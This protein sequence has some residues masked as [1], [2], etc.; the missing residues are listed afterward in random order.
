MLQAMNT[1]HEG[2]LSTAHA[3]SCRH[4]LWRLET[5]AM[6]SDVE[7]PA[8]H[9]RNAGCV[10]DRCRRA[11]RAPARR[12]TSRVGDRRRRGDASRRAGRDAAVPV[13]PRERDDDRCV[14][15]DRGRAGRRGRPRAIEARTSATGSSR[16]ARTDDRA[17]RRPVW[18][19]RAVRGAGVR[20]SL[21]QSG[22]AGR[23]GSNDGIGARLDQDVRVPAV[24]VLV[25]MCRGRGRMPSWRAAPVLV[26]RLRGHRRGPPAP[27][28]EGARSRGATNSSRT[29]WV[30]WP[31]TC[32]RGCRCRSRSPMPPREAEA[33]LETELCDLVERSISGTPLDEALMTGRMRRARTT[34][35]VV[36]VADAASS[37]RRRPSRRCSTVAA[38]LRERRAA[39]AR[40]A[41]SRA[42]ARLSGVILGLLP[43]GFFGFL[44]LTSR[45]DDARGASSTPT[46]GDGASA[47]VWC[48]RCV[49]FLW[50]RPSWRCG[51]GARRRAGTGGVVGRMRGR[52]CGPRG[53]SEARS[54]GEDAIRRS[55]I[56]LARRLRPCSERWSPA[57]TADGAARRAAR[58]SSPPASP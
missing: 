2:S 47:S 49:A 56:S 37:E 34:P 12:T 20:R 7:L 9:I 19:C 5:M 36:G 25:A 31:R 58:R 45:D 4:L 29:R 8:A 44:W 41:R 30:R 43:I 39:H 15:C 51:D 46:R 21:T 1:G 26:G 32:A 55:A 28:R 3:N 23:W 53:P 33:P 54:S 22:M 35:S 50:I 48:W 14:P 13:P 40:S 57:R 27:T 42:Q 17:G 18:R 24:A 16:K 38:T 6:M 11:A 52:R 10:R